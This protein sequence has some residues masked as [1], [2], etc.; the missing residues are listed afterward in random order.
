[1]STLLLMGT[2]TLPNDVQREIWFLFWAPA[3]HVILCTLSKAMTEYVLSPRFIK[4]LQT[5]GTNLQ[6]VAA[7]VP[8][9][10]PMLVACYNHSL[11]DHSLLVSKDLHSLYDTITL[12]NYIMKTC[13]D[14]TPHEQVYWEYRESARRIIRRTKLTDEPLRTVHLLLSVV[15]TL[16]RTIALGWAV[17]G[18]RMT[19][20]LHP[21]DSYGGEVFVP[22]AIDNTQYDAKQVT[23]HLG[24]TMMGTKCFFQINTTDVQPSVMG[25]KAQSRKRR[26]AFLKLY[27]SRTYK[28]LYLEEEMWECFPKAHV[29]LLKQ[30]SSVE[31]LETYFE[32]LCNH[33]EATGQVEG[34]AVI[35]YVDHLR[36]VGRWVSISECKRILD[37]LF[38]A[39]YVPSTE[40]ASSIALLFEHSVNRDSASPYITFLGMDKIAELELAHRVAQLYPDTYYE[41]VTRSEQLLLLCPEH[42]NKCS[43]HPLWKNSHCLR[44]FYD[45]LKCNSYWH[46]GGSRP[47]KET[48]ELYGKADFLLRSIGHSLQ[49]DATTTPCS[50]LL[51]CLVKWPTLSVPVEVIRRFVSLYIHAFLN[52]LI[53]GPKAVELYGDVLL[54]AITPQQLLDILK[55]YSRGYTDEN[56]VNRINH[57]VNYL[58]TKL[59]LRSN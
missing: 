29:A 52:T 22:V 38:V 7:S 48:K 43:K 31:K 5:E 46:P 15:S 9:S 51:I 47:S 35:T 50:L 55:E 4:R 17:D 12:D 39:K 59:L 1:M 53:R 40:D 13:I 56:N 16:L 24:K 21:G 37:L 30:A 32:C 26:D 23:K 28:Y 34:K 25:I 58:H 44:V 33:Y 18:Y 8:L 19:R 49:L 6:R 2:P 14:T 3:T 36:C 45:L 10:I 20:F 54:R 11:S 41:M 57:L 27:L 42:L